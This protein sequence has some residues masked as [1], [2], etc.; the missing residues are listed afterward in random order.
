MQNYINVEFPNKVFIY[1]TMQCNL[2]CRMCYSGAYKDSSRAKLEDLSLDQYK[3]IIKELYT[4]GVRIFDV[5]GGEPLLRA[6]LF[7]ILREIK[8]YDDT[9]TYVVSNGTLLSKGYEKIM[10]NI[11]LI[12]RLYISLDSYIEEKHNAIRGSS[13]AFRK[14]VDGIK[15]LTDAGV[16][17]LGINSVIMSSNYEDINGI[18]N[19]A[20]NVGARYINLLRLIDVADKENLI[21]ENLSIDTFKESLNHINTWIKKK[22]DEGFNKQFDITIVLP[23]YV[24]FELNKERKEIIKND[25]IRVECQFDPIKG[26]FAFNQSIVLTG[27]GNLTGCTGMVQF[28]EFHIGNIYDDYEKLKENWHK[29]SQFLKEREEKLKQEEPCSSCK[30]WKSCKG[31]CPA[32]AYRYYNTIM[33]SDPTCIVNQNKLL[34]EK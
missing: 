27:K 18:L 29:Q 34:S 6:D 4:K 5:S 14:T 9:V 7:E 20:V 23:G 11:G 3:R 32:S 8:S 16:E 15:M 1:P 31:G 17:N 2:N 33:K 13:N 19:M 28:D 10:K 21:N 12:N 26:C 22:L 25:Y 30:Y 24:M